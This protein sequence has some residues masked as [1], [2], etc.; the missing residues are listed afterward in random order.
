M[1]T[2]LQLSDF[3]IKESMLP[4]HENPVITSF[5]DLI[6]QMHIERPILV[7][8]GDIIDSRAVAD[9]IPDSLSDAKK[10]FNLAKDYFDFLKQELEIPDDRIII[11]CGNHDINRFAV[12]SDSFPCY[13]PKKTNISYSPQRFSL[14]K[15]FIDSLVLK[16]ETYCTHFRQIDGINFIVA[17]SNWTGKG[18]GKLCIAF[19]SINKVILEKQKTLSDTILQ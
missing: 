10:A 8:N 7:Y 18:S 5:V 6:R 2:I 17:N 13:D 19:D 1:K 9:K 14:V 16:S 12:G 3:H 11:C 4:P 15:G